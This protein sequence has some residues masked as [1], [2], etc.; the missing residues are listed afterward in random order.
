MVIW[1]NGVRKNGYRSVPA[2]LPLSTPLQTFPAPPPLQTFPALLTVFFWNFP[3]ETS[4]VKC[5]TQQWWSMRKPMSCKKT[6]QSP[7]APLRSLAR[8]FFCLPI[9]SRQFKYFW[10]WFSKSK[11]PGAPLNLI[12]NFHHRHSIVLTSC[13]WVSEDVAAFT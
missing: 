7:A 5:T 3:P 1:H 10:N 2:W 13:P 4:P 9:R 12:V 6:P 8:I 11:C